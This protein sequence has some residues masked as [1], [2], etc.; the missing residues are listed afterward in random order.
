[1]NFWQHVEHAAMMEGVFLW[2]VLIFIGGAL[3]LMALKPNERV[4]IRN[5]LFLFALSFAG[6][7]M[8]ASLAAH[9]NAKTEIYKWLRWASLICLCLAI[10]NVGSV[11]LFEVVLE[12]LRL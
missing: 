3:G 4:R 2:I 1:M 12:P 8:V 5:G 9:G 6:L 7:L 11:L 10:V